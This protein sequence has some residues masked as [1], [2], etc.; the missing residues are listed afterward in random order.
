[1]AAPQLMIRFVEAEGSL[2][3]LAIDVRITGEQPVKAQVINIHRL[4]SHAHT[5]RLAVIERDGASWKK[6][7]P[8]KPIVDGKGFLT[9]ELSGPPQQGATFWRW[10]VFVETNAGNGSLLVQLGQTRESKNIAALTLNTAKPQKVVLK[11]G[12]FPRL[13]VG[14]NQAS[15][16][17]G[18]QPAQDP[19]LGQ[20]SDLK[21]LVEHV[22]RRLKTPKKAPVA[23]QRP[24]ALEAAWLVQGGRPLPTQLPAGAKVANAEEAWARKV[25]EMLTL[26]P[27]AGTGFTYFDTFSDDG[28]F[29]ADNLDGRPAPR[30]YGLV[31]ACQHLAAFGVSSRGRPAHRFGSYSKL[32]GLKGRRLPNAGSSCSDTV[33]EAG[34]AWVIGGKPPTPIE[35]TMTNAGVDP[36]TLVCDAA[37]KTA[38][39]LYTIKGVKGCDFAPGALFVYANRPVRDDMGDKDNESIGSGSLV[40]GGYE[41]EYEN[42]RIVGKWKVGPSGKLLADNT[43]GAHV[44]FVL[45]TDP[46]VALEQAKP[47]QTALTDAKF[48]LLDTGGF[49]VLDRGEGVTV[50]DVQRRF[51]S[52]NFDG[53]AT[54]AIGQGVPYRGVGVWTRMKPSDGVALDRH[55]KDV[56]EVLRPLGLARL[57]MHDRAEKIGNAQ[58]G[59][60]GTDKGSWMLYASPLV[61]MYEADDRANYSIVR[62]AWSLRGLP[63]SDR[64]T[65]MWFI[66]LPKRPLARAMIDAGRGASLSTIVQE[67]FDRIRSPLVKHNLKLADGSI[68]AAKLLAKYTVPLLDI[69]V[70]A[71]GQAKISYKYPKQN[72]MS[73]LHFAERVGW[74]RKIRLP[75]DREFLPGGQ[76]GA[77][78]PAY[79][80]P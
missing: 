57:V 30:I 51:H 3:R 24:D 31:H 41:Y 66:Y 1:M 9:V 61:P 54:G 75:M 45:R 5:R 28:V 38:P 46:T 53:P 23:G 20:A 76:Q 6:V 35:P 8:P 50:L 47:G 27:Y 25:S 73:K 49:G 4:Q 16:A 19:R 65:A 32:S 68:N 14:I 67:A 12:R 64:V 74:D 55:V 21:L 22:V 52:G 79:L 39:V 78:F 40:H 26:T 71:S 29:L 15:V 7:D 58:I 17:S 37:L 33:T 62:Y 13:V 70:T 36:N 48:Q 72:K 60:I 59:E 43:D 77:G 10:E 42:N 18:T 56:L 80:R 63:A 2:L 69:G 11:V 34:G 44:G